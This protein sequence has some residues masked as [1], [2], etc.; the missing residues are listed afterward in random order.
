MMENDKKVEM[1]PEDVEGSFKGIKLAGRVRVVDYSGD[2]TVKV[3]EANPD[4]RVKVVHAYS[5]KIGEWQFVDHDEDFTV[6]FVQ[7]SPEL[8]IKLVDGAP[9]IDPDPYSAD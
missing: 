3:V 5:D 1:Y 6:K 2:I 9:G 7:K 8:R 4:L